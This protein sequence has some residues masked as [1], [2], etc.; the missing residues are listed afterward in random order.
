M[1]LFINLR[2]R[3]RKRF[4]LQE[5]LNAFTPLLLTS[6]ELFIN[7]TLIESTQMQAR[8]EGVTARG[9]GPPDHVNFCTSHRLP[10]NVDFWSK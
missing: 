6:C 5:N 7:A 10:A 1:Y 4:F 3:V 2:V 8:R 9:P